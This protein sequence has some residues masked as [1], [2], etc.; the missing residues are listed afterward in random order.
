MMRLRSPVMDFAWTPEQQA[1]REQARKVATEAVERYGRHNDSWINGFSKEFAV[2]MAAHGWIGM[3]WPVESGGGGQPPINRLIVG[4]ELIAAG[5][6]IAAMWFA[7]RQMG[8]TLIKYGTADQQAEF[9][10]GI[11]SGETTWCIGMSEPNAGSDL[12]SLATSARREGDDFVINGQK[13]WTSFGAQ[14]DYCYL[15]CR[16]SSEGPPHRGISEVIVPMDTP[17]I[18][19]RPITDMTTNRHFCEV[20]FTDVRV[21]VV[22]LVGVEGAAFKQTMAQLEHERGGIDRLVSNR[23]LYEMAAARADR[24]DPLVRQRMARLETGYRL[25]RILVTREVLRQA[26]AGFSAATKCFCTEHEIDVAEFVFDVL[27]AEGTLW[28]EVTRGLVYAPG[29][30]IMGGTSNVMRNILGERVLGLPRVA[31]A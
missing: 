27:G 15:I 14:A 26:P 12:A 16:T 19:V 30:T 2:E 29:Y 22:N 20:F 9:L 18:E 10:P 8:P 17:G 7:D 11:L 21:P 5:A 24:T 4:E 28:T 13:I 23:A 25:G 1:L 31:N 6:P 3:T